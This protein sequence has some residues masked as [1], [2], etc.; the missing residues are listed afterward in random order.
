MEGTIVL[1]GLGYA[2]AGLSVIP[3]LANSRLYYWGDLDTHGFAILDKTRQALPGL[4]SVLMDYETLSIHRDYWAEEKS[5][6]RLE[7]PSSLTVQELD[8]YRGLFANRW[9]QSVRLEQE[10][11]GWDY[12]LERL[13]SLL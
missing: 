4:K 8:V 7:E 9:G 2:A 13:K 6:C 5:P 10:R 1:M 12:A 11:I 3:W